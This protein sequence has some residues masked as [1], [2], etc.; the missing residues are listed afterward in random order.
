[1]AETLTAVFEQNWTIEATDTPTEKLRLF[2]TAIRAVTTALDNKINDLEQQLRDKD[3]RIAELEGKKNDNS[4][5]KE[6]S[7]KQ[8]TQAEVSRVRDNLIVYFK[9]G[10]TKTGPQITPDLVK[11][12]N[13]QRTSMGAND[14]ANFTKKN[15]EWE[16]LKAPKQGRHQSSKIY[17]LCL[18]GRKS[19][20][21]FFSVLKKYGNQQPFNFMSC[22][23]EL[24]QFLKSA[25]NRSERVAAV[26]RAENPNLK[27]RSLYN[28]KELAIDM[29]VGIAS[30]TGSIE[31]STIASSKP[32]EQ[33]ITDIPEWPAENE[34][35]EASDM[36]K[37][38]QT[39][40]DLINKTD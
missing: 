32:Q 5:L 3:E 2:K 12:M 14:G 34:H 17:R 28:A 18:T 4:H 35:P 29:Q 8:T 13:N 15:F 36:T 6:F 22:K 21:C 23:N 10:A 26:L 9:D 40:A 31:F 20:M 39:V 11:H 33:G 16:A 24:P 19:K 7:I 30:E 38:R 27:S 25:Y 1:M 37:I